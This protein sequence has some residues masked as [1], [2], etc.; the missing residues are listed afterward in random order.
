MP[1]P[2]TDG[3]GPSAGAPAEGISAKIS[4]ASLAMRSVSGLLGGVNVVMV[5]TDQNVIEA[6]DGIVGQNGRREVTRDEVRCDGVFV[7][8]HVAHREPGFDFASHARLLQADDALLGLADAQQK[9]AESG[10]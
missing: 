8:P 9:M 2:V 10:A 1:G 4:F 5:V 6:R 7:R 3:V